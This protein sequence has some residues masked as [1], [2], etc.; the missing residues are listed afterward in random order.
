[1]TFINVFILILYIIFKILKYVQIF[2]LLVE[3]SFPLG[4]HN[5]RNLFRFPTD[6]FNIQEGIISFSAQVCDGACVWPGLCV[7][8][9]PNFPSPPPPRFSHEQ[10]NTT[11]EKTGKQKRKTVRSGSGAVR[12]AQQSPGVDFYRVACTIKKSIILFASQFCFC[13][14]CCCCRCDDDCRIDIH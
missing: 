12:S 5:I 7:R 1:V 2:S 9:T 3:Y 11:G 14:R 4:T 6:I 8:R 10:Q 13:C